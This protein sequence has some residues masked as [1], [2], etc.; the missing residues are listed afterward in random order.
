MGKPHSKSQGGPLGYPTVSATL[1]QG[2]VGSVYLLFGP[3]RALSDKLIE[4]IKGAWLGA[5]DT[6]LS[7]FR[8]EGTRMRGAQ[9]ADMANQLPFFVEKQMIVVEEPA[10]I[11]A[12]GEKSGKKGASTDEPT[13]APTDAPSDGPTDA[14]T[15]AG[16]RHFMTYLE[17]PA[18]HTCLV[19]RFAQARPDRRSKA[20]SMI[21]ANG[22]L[23]E[24]ALLSPGEVA[25]CLQERVTA[26]G[27]KANRSLLTG[28]AAA[29]PDG[30]A[31]ALQ[32]LE[33]VIAY[34]G[35]EET[36]TADM[37]AQVTT[38]NLS[39]DIFRLV[40]TL[41]Q[42][43]AAKAME[44]LRRLL[45]CG[46]SPFNIFSMMLRQFRLI[47][48][49]KACLGARYGRGQIAQTLSCPP[50]VAE[51]VA[52][53]SK[54]FTFHELEQAMTLFQEKDLLLKSSVPPARVLED[55]ILA[56]AGGA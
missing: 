41:G 13:D 26:C 6:A 5:G 45:A 43:R 37:V 16:S 28:L 9:I 39:A 7:F 42:K 11:A 49:A 20:V 17:N 32:E 46:R 18:P 27:K 31:Y 47:F 36:L 30:L 25:A 14:P 22:G 40:D 56:L 51:K 21:A 23:V 4:E 1:A 15:D 44:E 48:Q 55:L 34:A 38:P 52:N 33:K 54:N 24:L 50:F 19:L 53:Q 8:R 12:S 3:E 35:E 10:F 2:Q 29:Q